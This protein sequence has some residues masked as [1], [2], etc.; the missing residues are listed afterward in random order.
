MKIYA[1]SD[2]RRKPV[3][4]DHIY[5]KHNQQ[6]SGWNPY[7]YTSKVLIKSRRLHTKL[8]IPFA[9]EQDGIVKE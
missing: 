8:I 1:Q 7:L 9:I 2:F 6:L 5:N 4:W 3:I